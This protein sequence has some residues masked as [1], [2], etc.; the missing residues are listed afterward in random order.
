M[1]KFDCLFLCLTLSVPGCAILPQGARETLSSPETFAV[2][3]TADVITTAIGLGSGAAEANPVMGWV[4]SHWGWI[5]FIGISAA[6]IWMAFHLRDDIHPDAM[7][8][9]NVITCA[10]A[11][12]NVVIINKLP[13]LGSV[14]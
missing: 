10:V 8:A 2:C 7:L 12:N 14:R 5:G 4:L 6:F 13:E 1:K 11:V 9:A 3:K